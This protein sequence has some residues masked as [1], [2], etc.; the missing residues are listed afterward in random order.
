MTQFLW[1]G[2]EDSDEEVSELVQYKCQYEK[3]MGIKYS[4]NGIIKFV[5]AFIANE[6][7]E[8]KKDPKMAKAWEEKL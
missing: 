8:N 5:T 6:R 7:K 1:D 4:K 2:P 3:E